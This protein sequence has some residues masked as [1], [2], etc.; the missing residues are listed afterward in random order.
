ML[1]WAIGVF[2][3]LLGFSVAIYL[4][5]EKFGSD[6]S[7]TSVFGTAASGVVFSVVIGVVVLL[8]VWPPV[9]LASWLFFVAFSAGVSLLVF[10]G[11]KRKNK[12]TKDSVNNIEIINKR[13]EARS[14]T[15]S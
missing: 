7:T 13:D 8:V 10:T 4:V 1:F 9:T 14:N 6:L 5:F 2:S 12:G 11:D 15:G 3:V